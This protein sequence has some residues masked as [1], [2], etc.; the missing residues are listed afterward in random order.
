MKKIVAATAGNMEMASINSEYGSCAT[1]LC[2]AQVESRIPT[3]GGEMLFR[4]QNEPRG[5]LEVAA[6]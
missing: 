4:P 1:C 6:P 5:K 3:A 2:G